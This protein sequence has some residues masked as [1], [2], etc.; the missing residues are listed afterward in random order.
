MFKV[1]ASSATLSS[2][3]SSPPPVTRNKHNIKVEVGK[4]LKMYKLTTVLIF[5]HETKTWVKKK[6]NFSKVQAP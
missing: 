1:N 3:S 2:S 6:K 5:S 4:E